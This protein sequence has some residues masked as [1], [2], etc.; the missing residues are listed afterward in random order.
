MERIIP[1]FAIVSLDL[2]RYPGVKSCYLAGDDALVNCDLLEISSLLYSKE[3]QQHALVIP[4]DT[5]S[6]TVA[7][8]VSN[9]PNKPPLAGRPTPRPTQP[10]EQSSAVA[11]PL[12]R[13]VPWKCIAAMIREYKSCPGCH[14]KHPEDSQR[15]KFHQE[16]GYPELAKHGHL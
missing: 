13:G 4:N 12:P 14:Y 1:L 5:L 16:L 6:T 11:Y 15:L 2:D 10:P 7:N 3:T 8:L 9:T